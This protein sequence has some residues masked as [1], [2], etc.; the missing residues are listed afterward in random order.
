[1]DAHGW[2]Y[3]SKCA[4]LTPEEADKLFF[5]GTGGKPHK[6]E[7]FCS[8][9]PFRSICLTD[10]IEKNLKGFFAGTTDDDRRRMG[11]LHNIK[12]SDLEMPPEPPSRRVYRKIFTP[13][14]PREWLDDPDLVPSPLELQL[15]DTI[16]S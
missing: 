15:I 4:T 14:D 13:T 9:C 6:A 2:R 1:M 10:A 8:S 3:R 12:V 5:P 7:R 16:A 11:R